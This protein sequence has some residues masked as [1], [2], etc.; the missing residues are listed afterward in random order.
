MTVTCLLVWVF[1]VQVHNDASGELS[2]S[3]VLKTVGGANLPLQVQRVF[4]YLVA[5][6]A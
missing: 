1:R 3:G 4:G 6:Q 5:Y 2:G